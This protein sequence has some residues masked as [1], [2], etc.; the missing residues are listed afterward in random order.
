MEGSMGLKERYGA[1]ALVTG[2]SSGIGRAL[3]RSLAAG[4]MSVVL[5]ADDPE[6]LEEAAAEVRAEAVEARTCCVDL[7]GPGFHAD[8]RA[9]TEGISISLLA[10]NASFGGVGPFL[11]HPLDAYDAM[12][13]VNARAY[14]A[15]THAYL[16]GMV[17]ADRGALIFVSSLNAQ[18]PIANSSVYTAT[19]AFDLFFGG[20]LWWE[21]RDTGVDV[22]VLQP[23]P[24]RTGFQAK[25]QTQLATWAMEPEEVAAEA[26]AALGTSAFHIAGERN[27]QIAAQGES[28]PL[29]QRIAAASQLLEDALIRGVEPSL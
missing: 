8:V 21:L 3:A 22:L 14:V 15:L 16:P 20:A 6:G 17:E 4:G 13:A 5:V 19:K 28:L 11:A 1:W 23:G 24:T 7:G 25:A 29:E 10:N 9:A 27:R 18:A 2:A 26:L 12:I